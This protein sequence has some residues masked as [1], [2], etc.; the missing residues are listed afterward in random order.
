MSDF[1]Q[2]KRVVE[3]VVENGQ[4]LRDVDYTVTKH[5]PNQIVV[6]GYNRDQPFIMTN[7]T[8][9]ALKKRLVGDK[10]Q[11]KTKA[12]TKKTRKLYRKKK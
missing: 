8:S 12:K 9:S 6:Q 11:K 3:R 2:Q 10:K 4:V 7:M 5:G 1:V